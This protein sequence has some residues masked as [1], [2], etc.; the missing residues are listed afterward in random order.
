MIWHIVYTGNVTRT[1]YPYSSCKNGCHDRIGIFEY[2]PDYW[3]KDIPF[4]CARLQFVYIFICLNK[5][6]YMG[7]KQW[8]N[9]TAPM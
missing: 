9:S 2:I 1:A 4:C 7:T 6:C 8:E 5:Q 3:G